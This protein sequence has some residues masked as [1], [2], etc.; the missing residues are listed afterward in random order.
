MTSSVSIC[1]NALIRLGDKPISSF[2]DG[3][4]AANACAN[5]YRSVR[6]ALLRTHPWNCATKR[7]VL[8][9][10]TAV[11]A[12]DYAYQYQLPADWL[13]T[14]Q[15]GARDC[16]LDFTMEG[17]RILCD[18]NSLPLVYIFQ[19]TIESTWDDMLVELMTLK[20]ASALAYPITQSASMAQVS[21]AAFQ[22]A[23]KQAKAQNGQDDRDETL[24]DFP[25]LANRLNGYRS[26]PGR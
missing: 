9:P 23:F 6:D 4:D 17:Q 21:E 11:P 3:T 1:S 18:A 5:L 7:V 22:L 10:L 14:I 24:G 25:L 15:V 2:E 8:A 16:G 19:N 13:R 12:F 20:M 26:V